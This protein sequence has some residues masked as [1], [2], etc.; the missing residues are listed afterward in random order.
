MKSVGIVAEGI[1]DYVVIRNILYGFFDEEE[2]MIKPIQPVF[3]ETQ[4]AAKGY[5]AQNSEEFGGWV[6][7]IDYCK[8]Q[9]RLA[10]DIQGLD[11]LIIQI[12]TD[13][14]EEKGFD[15]AKNDEKNQELNTSELSNKVIEKLQNLIVQAYTSDFF[16]F[17]QEKIIFAIA[18]HSTECWLLPL[19]ATQKA[20][21]QATKNCH[22]RLE[23]VLKEKVV[24]KE[25]TYDDLS[26]KFMKYNELKK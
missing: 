17:Y 23:K 20:D 21:V 9:E 18:V 3:D 24:K 10:K 5:S 11:Y 6:N 13:T 8:H 26:K 16:N 4:K 2:P 7:V 12:D 22:K 19:H 25:K 15:V 14:S 1:T